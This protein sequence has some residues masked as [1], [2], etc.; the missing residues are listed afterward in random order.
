MRMGLDTET[1]LEEH[2]KIVDLLIKHDAAP[3]SSQDNYVPRNSIDTL[4]HHLDA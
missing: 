4:S 1:W 3:T 2:H